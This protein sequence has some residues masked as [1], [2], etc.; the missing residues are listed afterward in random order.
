MKHAPARLAALAALA[1]L[2]AC[3]SDPTSPVSG[4]WAQVAAGDQFTCALTTQGAAWC[5]GSALFGQLGNNTTTPSPV[6]VAVAGAHVFTTISAGSDHACAIDGSGNTWCWG[7]NDFSELGSATGPC[8]PGFAFAF[9]ARV[10]RA[11]EQAPLFASVAV[12]G[13]AS[14][15]VTAAGEVFCWGWSDHG[16]IGSIPVGEEIDHPTKITGGALFLSVSLDIYHACGLTLAHAISCWGSDDHGQ[17]STD[18]ASTVRCGSGIGEF[19]C[20][21]TP[22]ASAPGLVASRI[23]TGSTHTCAIDAD[24]GSWCWGSNQYGVLGNDNI[25]RSGSPVPVLG[26]QVFASI[27]AGEAHT[28]ALT[29][30]GDAWCW[31]VNSVGQLGVAS[32]GEACPAFG[33][34]APCATKPIRVAS[35]ESFTQIS[36]GSG[37]TCGVTTQGEILCWGLGSAGQLGNGGKSST[38]TPTLVMHP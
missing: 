6:P 32:V 36:A 24:G 28:C 19:D 13:Y 23:S 25:L 31:G 33:S 1:V 29:V 38:A 3:G 22:V 21:A 14:C 18:T 12:S 4:P 37:H 9:C 27:D 7:L 26:G 5:W 8:N 15:G 10:P 17:L 2:T 16:Q 30:E 35:A 11:V 34:A 20:T